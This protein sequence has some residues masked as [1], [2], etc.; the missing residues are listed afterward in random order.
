MQNKSSNNKV[1]QNYVKS[2]R[3]IPQA[4]YHKV[5][6]RKKCWKCKRNKKCNEWFD[7]HHIIP[8]SDGGK[9][10][11]TN[12]VAVC[13]QCHLEIHGLNKKKRE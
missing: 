6:I 2:G 12:L 11:H 10:I 1:V 3:Y 7:V 5:K 4:L 13:K 8:I 9:S